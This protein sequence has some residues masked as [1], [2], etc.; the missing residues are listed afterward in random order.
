MGEVFSPIG[1]LRIYFATRCVAY[2]LMQ[3]WVQT[4]KSISEPH[5]SPF[6]H[7]PKCIINLRQNCMKNTW[8]FWKVLARIHALT[9]CTKIDDFKLSKWPWS[10]DTW[11]HQIRYAVQINVDTWHFTE[12][13]II[14]LH[15]F[16]L[17][18]KKSLILFCFLRFLKRVRY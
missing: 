12:F 9:A 14:L 11:E 1:I 13:Q 18:K 17:N 10:C 8:I 7:I 15:N 2:S 4:L 16:F 5:V 6:M 3:C